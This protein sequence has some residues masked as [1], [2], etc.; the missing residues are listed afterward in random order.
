MAET[1]TDS[2]T[3]GWNRKR[4]A[5][6]SFPA[7]DPTTVSP[8]SPLRRAQRYLAS[9]YDSVSSLIETTY[10]ALREQRKGSR[11]RLTH[12]EHDIFRAALV[13]AGA[14]VD[15]VFK[16]ALR[17]CVPIQLDASEDARKKYLGFVER[18]ITSGS[19][20]NTRR[21]AELLISPNSDEELRNV[22]IEWLTGSSLQS[23]SQVIN[24]LSA[25]GFTDGTDLFKDAKKLDPLFRMR[26]EIAHEMDMTPTAVGRGRGERTRRER[27]IRTSIGHCHTGLSYCQRM[28]NQLQT[29]LDSR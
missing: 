14:G 24:S 11:G 3:G 27:A 8:D 18:N 26:N 16:E 23:R 4:S 29:E 6:T 1:D 2:L 9:A 13:F 10:P 21:L 7:L 25:L 17:S 19:G 22:Y 5:A 20:L 12:A 15:T 28:L